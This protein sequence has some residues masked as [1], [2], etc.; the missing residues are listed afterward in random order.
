[1]HRWGGTMNIIRRAVGLSIAAGL[2]ACSDPGVRTEFQELR[3]RI[4]AAEKSATTLDGFN[5]KL[6]Y[7]RRQPG[8]YAQY[9]NWEKSIQTK[10]MRLTDTLRS[11]AW[12]RVEMIL[13]PAKA[14]ETGFLGLSIV[15]DRVSL[16]M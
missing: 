16:R 8:D 13:A 5:V 6:R 2:G 4:E 9:A 15:V 3:K 10:E 12:N 14:D 1:V 11:G 7:G